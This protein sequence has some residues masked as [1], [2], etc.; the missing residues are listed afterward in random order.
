M[1]WAM[2]MSGFFNAKFECCYLKERDCNLD[3][4]ITNIQHNC[5]SK[6]QFTAIQQSWEFS[7][8]LAKLENQAKWEPNLVRDWPNTHIPNSVGVWF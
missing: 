2:G 7:S 3:N 5:N 1:D 8:W 4:K 6:L